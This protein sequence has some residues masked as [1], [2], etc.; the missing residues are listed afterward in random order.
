MG[1][2]SGPTHCSPATLCSCARAGD[3]LHWQASLALPSECKLAPVHVCIQPPKP[4]QIHRWPCHRRLNLF[5]SS[6]LNC[7]GNIS[8][9]QHLTWVLLLNVSS[10]T[11][12]VI[13]HG[14]FCVRFKHETKPWCKVGTLLRARWKSCQLFSAN[15]CGHQAAHCVFPRNTDMDLKY[16]TIL[17]GE[18]VSHMLGIHLSFLPITSW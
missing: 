9:S 5:L 18:H 6:H 17:T 11:R 3:R 10:P 4:H 1:V 15:C 16:L 2:E 12:S 8:F 13:L 14:R 7:T